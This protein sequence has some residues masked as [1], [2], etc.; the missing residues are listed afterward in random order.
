MAENGFIACFDTGSLNF[1]LE[2]AKKWPSSSVV[3]HLSI[4]P[5]KLTLTRRP[6]PEALAIWILPSPS[7]ELLNSTKIKTFHSLF[8]CYL[9][10]MEQVRSGNC[11]QEWTGWNFDLASDPSRPFRT[12]TFCDM[13]SFDLASMK[14]R[15]STI[16]SIRLVRAH[17]NFKWKGASGSGL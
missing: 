4:Y 10:Q 1:P 11:K 5:Y 16:L 8:F 12:D 6:L 15:D 13:S 3:G 9:L 14:W 2:W 17:W 7:Q